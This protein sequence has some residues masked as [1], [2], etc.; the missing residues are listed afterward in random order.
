[1]HHRRSVRPV[2]VL[3]AAVL[4]PA[5][6][7]TCG[8]AA[9]PRDPNGNL[10]AGLTPSHAEGV[11][12]VDRL[13]DGVAAE[14]GD[15]WDTDLTS[16]LQSRRSVVEF[17]LGS[18]KPIRCALVQGDNNDSYHLA[19]SLDGRTWTP[20]YE[21]PPV[22]G[23]GLRTR[24]GHLDAMARYVRLSAD[25]GDGM[26]AVGEV[27]VYETCPT[28]WPPELR[29]AHG[30]S[31]EDA[32]IFSV[33]LFAVVLGAYLFFV[34]R[35]GGGPIRLALGLV[36][37]AV[38]VFNLLPNLVALYPL[39]GVETALRASIAA[40]AAVVVVRE[41]FSPPSHQLDRRVAR[42]VLGLLALGA[43]GCYYHFGSLQFWDAAKGRKSLV[44]TFDMRHYFPVAKYFRELRFDGLYDASLAAYVDLHPGMSLND[45]GNVK[46]RDLNTA[47]MRRVR[48]MIP[49]IEAVRARFSPERWE[50]FKRDMK[51][52]LD[53]MGPGDYLGS[54]SD[55]GGNATPVWILGAYAIFAHT[56]ASELSLS[57]AG[58][59]DPLLVLILFVVV[60]RTFG[61]R[62]AL[63]VMI[64]F[65]ATD[66]YQFGSNLV[67]STLRQDWLVATGLGACAI[68]ARRPLLGGV[69]IAYAGLI[70]AF[71]AVAA[72][73]LPVPVLWAVV[74]FVRARRRLPRGP[75][76]R[77]IAG[78]QR[79]SLRA[80]AGAALAVVVLI[81]VTS[82]MFGWKGAWGN[83]FRKIEVHATGPSVNN[84]GLRNVL[85]F[86]PSHIGR[87]VIREGRPEPWE[88]WQQYEIA[89]FARRRPLFW[90]GNALMLGLV[91]LACRG[92]PLE[93][94]ALLGLLVV[95][96]IFYPSNY[97]CHY[98]FLLPMAAA[99]RDGSDEHDKPFAIGVLALMA[100]CVAQG[101]SYF[102]SWSDVRFTYQSIALLLGSLV[103]VLPLAWES[104]QKLRAPAAPA[105]A[106]A[107]AAAA[108][109]P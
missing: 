41:A 61:A 94:V 12:N 72:M 43:L 82:A 42:G 81:L 107:P 37:L 108:P 97:Y 83:W 67:G 88:A 71:P 47:D 29:R 30:T 79:Q 105:P 6:L 75:E 106:A 84:V 63:Y 58:L 22:G 48:E 7:A 23:A 78:V 38:A 25:G 27:A 18:E 52:F 65:G 100:M 21:G 76:L 24:D 74:D 85:M 36:P 56:P 53:T 50:E 40:L 80:T 44:H 55:H 87:N 99:A 51:Y 103:F 1:M 46:L 8:G 90:L 2:L 91:L 35:K 98:V 26:Y 34:S 66:F 109:Q 73:V 9:G 49:D 13:T 60:W 101:F 92:R 62:V 31:T 95:P 57:L 104:W 59:I 102:E 96:F 39:F 45:V 33:V 77:E 69:L 28:P 4:S 68:R 89:A 10:L 19:G 15:F 16:R 32:A 5:F 54:M 64:V 14:E 17:D 20:L 70:R 86:E 3:F 11:R 93:Q